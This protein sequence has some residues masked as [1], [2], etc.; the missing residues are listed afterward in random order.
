MT[1]PASMYFDPQVYEDEQEKIFQNSWQFVAHGAE[2]AEPGQYI[3]AEIAGQRAFV[4]R[5]D[6]GELGAYFNVCRTGATRCS[7]GRAPWAA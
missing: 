3:T 7:A 2:V 6:D 5:G 1:L 4:I